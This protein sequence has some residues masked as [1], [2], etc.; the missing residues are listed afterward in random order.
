MWTLQRKM[1]R[2]MLHADEEGYCA[3]DPD[4]DGE[5]SVNTGIGVI[6]PV[7]DRLSVVGEIGL[8]SERF[9]GGEADSRILGGVNWRVGNQATLRGAVAF[10]LDDGAPDTQLLA[11]YAYH[12]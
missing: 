5:L 10:G 6:V 11:G 12:F 1:L 4:L 2:W 3:Y 7:S 9:D 8:E